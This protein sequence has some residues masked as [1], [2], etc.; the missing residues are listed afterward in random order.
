MQVSERNI[1]LSVS[2]LNGAYAGGYITH[3]CGTVRVWSGV[4]CHTPRAAVWVYAAMHPH[5]NVGIV[6]LLFLREMPA[7]PGSGQYC[8]VHSKTAMFTVC[9]E[10]C[11][12]TQKTECNKE[13]GQYHQEK[14]HAESFVN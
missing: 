10:K 8:L 3:S 12:R 2:G 11:I 7:T 6:P 14:F 13:T 4:R 5:K 9:A 1:V